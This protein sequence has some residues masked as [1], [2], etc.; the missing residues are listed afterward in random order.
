[1]VWSSLLDGNERKEE[2]GVWNK[3]LDP[4]FLTVALT[5]QPALSIPKEKHIVILSF[6]VGSAPLSYVTNA[7]LINNKRDLF[8]SIHKAQTAKTL[9]WLWLHSLFSF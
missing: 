8:E 3:L 7:I 6:H 5:A 2:D 4:V 1:M 9:N